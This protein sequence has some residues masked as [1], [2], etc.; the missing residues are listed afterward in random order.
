MGLSTVFE[1]LMVRAMRARHYDSRF[2]RRWFA[3]R[4]GIE[5]GLYTYGAFDRWRVPPGTRIGRWCSFSSTVRLVDS[6][7]PIGALSTHPYFYEAQHGLTATDQVDAAHKV[8]E[9]DVWFGHNAMVTARCRT[10]GRGAIIGASAV[11]VDDVPPYAIVVGNPGRIIRYRFPPEVIEAVESTRW[12]TLDHA[13]LARRL[14]RVPGFLE[15]PT[16][17]GA[18][19][20][21][22]AAEAR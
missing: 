3:R 8:I 10:I 11:V 12:W 15:A 7:H 5:I 2:L 6:N 13:E 16:P 21:L 4:Y 20:F 17:E 9:D 18:K 19:A 22:A 1:T 14:A